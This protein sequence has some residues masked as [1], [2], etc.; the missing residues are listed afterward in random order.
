MG[1]LRAAKVTDSIFLCLRFRQTNL[2]Y[3]LGRL[4][5]LYDFFLVF[6]LFIII[7]TALLSQD[8]DG[9]HII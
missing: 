2:G 5:A 4:L 6:V 9:Y 8:Q 3:I 1:P 7:I